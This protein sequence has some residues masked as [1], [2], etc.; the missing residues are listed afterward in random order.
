[1]AG[2]SLFGYLK[3]KWELRQEKRS[4]F[5]Y[6]KILTNEYNKLHRVVSELT[7]EVKAARA[8]RK[9][10][11]DALARKGLHYFGHAPKYPECYT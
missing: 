2:F 11:E 4:L 9:S 10:V 3:G 1:M 5:K 8:S 7:I 6:N